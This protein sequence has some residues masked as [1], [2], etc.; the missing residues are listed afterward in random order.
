MTDELRESGE[1]ATSEPRTMRQRVFGAAF[2]IFGASLM[3]LLMAGPLA[4]LH[5]K[6]AVGPFQS[7]IE[8][9][10]APIVLIVKSDVKPF[11]TL[12]KAYI[13]LFT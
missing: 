4:F 8:T 1:Q 9:I 12:L 7:A 3:Y 2:A 11:S 13:G 10:F 6:L 5:K